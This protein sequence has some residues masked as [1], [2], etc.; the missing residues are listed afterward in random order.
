[1]VELLIAVPFHAFFGVIVM[2]TAY[3]LSE[4]FAAASRSLDVDPLADQATG[5]AIAWGFGDAWLTDFLAQRDLQFVGRRFVP[6]SGGRT[7]LLVFR[8]N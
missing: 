7:A 1:L 6:L 5:G 4:T 8:R 3:P 2:Q